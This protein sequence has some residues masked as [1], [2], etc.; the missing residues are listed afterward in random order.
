[1]NQK[2][3]DKETTAD[4]NSYILLYILQL[5]LWIMSKGKYQLRFTIILCYKTNA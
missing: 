1:M 4:T 3:Q 2:S 5:L